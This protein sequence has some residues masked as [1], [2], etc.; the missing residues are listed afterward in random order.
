MNPYELNG[1]PTCLEDLDPPRRQ[2]LFL[3]VGPGVFEVGPSVI[4]TIATLFDVPREPN[5]RKSRRNNKPTGRPRI[6]PDKLSNGQ[7]EI[8]FRVSREIMERIKRHVDKIEGLC[9]A[10]FAKSAFLGKLDRVE[11]VGEADLEEVWDRR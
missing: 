10:E 7:P 5:G 6:S 8:R 9:V 11:R 2:P 4:N 1:P 3:E